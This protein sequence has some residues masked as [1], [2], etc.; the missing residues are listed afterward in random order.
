MPL[1]GG[2]RDAGFLRGIN[3]ELM[4]Q[5]ISDEIII[6]KID[7]SITAINLYGEAEERKYKPGVRVFAK[8]TPEDLNTNSNNDI[9]DMDR[10]MTFSILKSDLKDKNLYVEEGDIVFYDSMYYEVDD[11]NQEKYWTNR[12]PNTNI[13]MTNDN[14][15]LHGYDHTIILKAHLTKRE[16]LNI[17]EVRTGNNVDDYLNESY[18]KV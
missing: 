6:Y 8:I 16:I 4:H 11:S 5:V 9:L 1:Y 13:G 17:E 10:I 15:A 7:N 14:W 3:R 2:N 18:H 12:D